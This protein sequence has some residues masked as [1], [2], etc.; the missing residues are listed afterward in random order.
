MWSSSVAAR[1]QRHSRAVI[2]R[3]CP[4]GLPFVLC[5][6]R[7]PNSSRPSAGDKI[8][9]KWSQPRGGQDLRHLLP[10]RCLAALRGA[11]TLLAGQWGPCPFPAR[12]LSRR[13]PA[14]LDP[15]SQRVRAVR[16]L[17]RRGGGV[18]TRPCRPA[19]PGLGRGENSTFVSSANI[20]QAAHVLLGPAPPTA[21]ARRAPRH[22]VTS[23]HLPPS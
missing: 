6:R 2:R 15:W 10:P 21:G 5:P 9:G 3:T 18:A 11:E 16:P 20:D 4:H 13:A 8:Y 22:P 14:L 17:G 19:C 7:P 1:G 23:A 12:S